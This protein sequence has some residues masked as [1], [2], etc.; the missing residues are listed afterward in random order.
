MKKK[1]RDMKCPK[2]TQIHTGALH[3]SGSTTKRLKEAEQ[4]L[5]DILSNGYGP[6]V[7]KEIVHYVMKYNLIEL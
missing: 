6:K 3:S 4:L 5:I 1:I 2:D 7:Q